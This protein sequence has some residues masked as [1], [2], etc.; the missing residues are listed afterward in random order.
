MALPVGSIIPK[1]DM[2]TK[3]TGAINPCEAVNY[4]DASN[5]ILLRSRIY[6]GSFVIHIF[7]LV[8]YQHVPFSVIIWYFLKIIP[9]L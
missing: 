7:G 6:I 9:S 8:P 2:E 3:T 1:E 4:I 5:T